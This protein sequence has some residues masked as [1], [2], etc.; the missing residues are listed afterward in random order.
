MRAFPAIAVI[1][2]LALATGMS[3]AQ[4]QYATQVQPILTNHC[5]G[6]HG[7]GSLDFRTYASVMASTSSAY[8]RAIVQPGNP[9]FS[10][11]YDKLLPNPQFGSR[12]PLGGSLTAN[13][14]EL[15]RTWISQGA[16]SL[17]VLDLP[18]ELALSQNYPNPF[19]PSTVVG[20]R[21]AVGG[22]TRLTVHDITGREVARLVD[23][24]FPAGS[25][26]VTFDASALPSGV[27]LYRLN[28][29]MGSITRKM[30]LMR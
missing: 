19:N 3:H 5:A 23:A 11:L 10:P 8:G 12:M 26:Q 13:Q 2:I 21:L 30:V 16:T 24:V 7:S 28:T 22:Q 17:E 6:C 18:G 20:W 14:I 4:V 27:Y 29:D 9:N 15:I 1:G 25:H